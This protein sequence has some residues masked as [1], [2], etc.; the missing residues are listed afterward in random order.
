MSFRVLSVSVLLACLVLPASAGSP[1]A[2]SKV[3]PGNI[4]STCLALGAA[5]ETLANGA[6]CR[7]T[8][9]GAAVDCSSGQC[10]DYFA[11]PRY[12]KIKAILKAGKTTPQ[13]S[14]VRL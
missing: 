4:A 12:G 9:T 1:P 7:N 13:K 5:G 8:K 3:T 14:P 6:G 11:D 2:K 10:T